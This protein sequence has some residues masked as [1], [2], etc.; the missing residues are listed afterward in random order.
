MVDLPTV[1]KRTLARLRCSYSRSTVFAHFDLTPNNILIAKHSEA[2]T[3][4][5]IALVNGVLC[6]V[7]A[8]KTQ[9]FLTDVAL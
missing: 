2:T 7:A 5:V 6:R 9:K 1:V 4:K 3:D 8:W